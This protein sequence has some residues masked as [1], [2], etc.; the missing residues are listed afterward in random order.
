MKWIPPSKSV[1]SIFSVYA[2][3]AEIF[4]FW[5]PIVGNAGRALGAHNEKPA[6]RGDVGRA[7]QQGGG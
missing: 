7:A 4:H 1:N 3:L 2:F 5:R 6:Q